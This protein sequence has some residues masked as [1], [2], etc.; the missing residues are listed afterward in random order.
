MTIEMTLLMAACTV[1]ATL[2]TASRVFGF[3]RLVDRS[4]ATDVVFTIGVMLI[5][6]G[7]LGGTLVAM[8]SGLMMAGVL[9]ACKWVRNTGRKVRPAQENPYDDINH[10]VYTRGLWNNA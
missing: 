6:S 8:L 3:S 2:L 4:T 1:A 10:P 7:T 5:F 9:S